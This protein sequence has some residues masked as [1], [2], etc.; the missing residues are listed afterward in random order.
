MT[1]QAS[2]K[3]RPE[4][5]PDRL[6]FPFD[7]GELHVPME[8]MNRG[9]SVEFFVEKAEREPITNED[10]S[11]EKREPLEI[12]CCRRSSNGLNPG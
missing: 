1:T 12:E 4:A 10:G 8:V 11:V 5:V 2:P 6:T 7:P 3:W 9:V